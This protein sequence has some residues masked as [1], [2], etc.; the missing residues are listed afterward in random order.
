[1]I[2][3]AKEAIIIRRT[4]GQS[5]LPGKIL[6]KSSAVGGKAII[7]FH[8]NGVGIPEGLEEQIFDKKFTLKSS[9]TGLG[10]F[11]ARFLLNELGCGRI[12][13]NK[14]EIHGYVTKVTVELISNGN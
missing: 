8:D 1:V 3:N 4:A 6:I 7:T 12:Y 10:L 11:N 9:G 5:E 2:K 14:S 13:A